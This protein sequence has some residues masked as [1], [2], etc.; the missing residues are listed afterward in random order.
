MAVQPIPKGYHS[1]NAVLIVPD[2]AGRKAIEFYKSVFGATESV[3]MADTEGR[4]MHAEIKIGDSIVML[5]DEFPQGHTRSPQ[6]LG[7]T[8]TSLFLYVP[9]VD[10]AFRR[11]VEAGA[12]VAMP[13][14]DMFWGDRFGTVADPFGHLWG[15]ATHKEDVSPEEL[16]KRAQA[17]M[18]AMAKGQK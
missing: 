4:L 7:G 12:T 2:G 1:V 13:L 18:A 10:A 16:K 17:A 8:T 9:D 14:A 6:N 3:F 15:L 11:A 5:S